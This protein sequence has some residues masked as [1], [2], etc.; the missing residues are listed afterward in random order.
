MDFN[1]FLVIQI[2]NS[3]FLWI[4]RRQIPGQRIQNWSFCQKL[5]HICQQKLLILHSKFQHCFISNFL[6]VSK[7]LQIYLSIEPN[8]YIFIVHMSFL[9]VKIKLQ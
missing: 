4:K 7:L 6:L 1:C 9:L 8:V 5:L 2:F 3:H